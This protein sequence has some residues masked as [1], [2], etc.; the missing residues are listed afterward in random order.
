VE[1]YYF[2]LN[3]FLI[4]DNTSAADSSHHKLFIG[5]IKRLEV[6]EM[7]LAEEKSDQQTAEQDLRTAHDSVAALTRELMSKVTALEESSGRKKAAQDALRMLADE[8]QALERELNSTRKPFDERDTSTSEVIAYA[9]GH[10]VGLQKS[11]CPIMIRSCY[12]KITGA[13]LML[14]G[15]RLWMMCTMQLN[16]SCRPMIS[17]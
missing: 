4:G 17:P 6:T 8:K 7:A 16:A 3:S 15:M 10:V 14:S 1:Q 5:L 12:V 9:V 2:C 13:N 11:M